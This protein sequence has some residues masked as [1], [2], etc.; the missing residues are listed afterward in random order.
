[1]I[2]SNNVHRVREK[3][4]YDNEYIY[5]I[6]SG[7]I[8]DPITKSSIKFIG[9]PSYNL[10][11]DKEYINDIKWVSLNDKYDIEILRAPGKNA[12]FPGEEFKDPNLKEYNSWIL[13]YSPVQLV[14][15]LPSR[16][17]KS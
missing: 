3:D 11:L 12:H 8:I 9:K 1:M 7:S 5:D 4:N 13:C 17:R 2:L 6:S 14:Y 15:D 16:I 10:D